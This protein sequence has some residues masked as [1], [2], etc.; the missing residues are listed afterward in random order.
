ME[1]IKMKKKILVLNHQ[2]QLGGVCIAAKNFIENMKEDYEIE[3]IFADVKK[4]KQ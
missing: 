1:K 4:R 2:M 3:Y